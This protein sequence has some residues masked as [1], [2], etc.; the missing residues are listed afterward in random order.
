MESY[1]SSS[2]S[3]AKEA[4]YS[5]VQLLI[6]HI[7]VVYW[8]LRVIGYAIKIRVVINVLFPDLKLGLPIGNLLR[9]SGH[10]SP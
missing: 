7:S 8:N 6:A 10:Y 9:A 4:L 3:F 5:I 1:I 2:V